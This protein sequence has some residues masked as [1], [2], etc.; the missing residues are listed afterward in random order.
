MVYLRTEAAASDFVAILKERYNVLASVMGPKT[1][2]F[3]THLDVS[4]AD[5]A[6]AA[7]A[8]RAAGL[9]SASA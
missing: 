7:E 1:A 2:R 3:V 4:A 5:V 9:E 8:I 6:C